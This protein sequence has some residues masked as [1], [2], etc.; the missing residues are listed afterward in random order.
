MPELP[1]RPSRRR[2]PNRRMAETVNLALG[3]IIL[4]ATVGF[5]AAGNPAE[6]FLSGAKDGSGMASILEDASVVISVALQHGI[7]ATALARSI[8]RSPDGMG[9]IKAASVIGAAL[10]LIVEFET[11]Q[12]V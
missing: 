3:G 8:S 9:H 7:P 11:R 12:H 5:D 6:V 1:P 2:L 10:D 4:S